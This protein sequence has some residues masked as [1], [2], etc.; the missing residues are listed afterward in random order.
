MFEDAYYLRETETENMRYAI[1][2]ATQT[3][4]S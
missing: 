3:C 1:F 2:P 4:L